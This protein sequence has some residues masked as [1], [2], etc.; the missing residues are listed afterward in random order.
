MYPHG[1]HPPHITEMFIIMLAAAKVI[2]WSLIF[3]SLIEYKFK[4][5]LIISLVIIFFYRSMKEA[6]GKI[7]PSQCTNIKQP[8]NKPCTWHKRSKQFKISEKVAIVE[9]NVE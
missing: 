2:S 8:R 9:K 3:L 5:N 7:I 4:Y 6:N 1:P